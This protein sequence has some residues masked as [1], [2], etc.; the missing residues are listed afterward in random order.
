MNRRILYQKEESS[1]G[2]DADF[3]SIRILTAR[4]IEQV[5]D[6]DISI[7]IVLNLLSNNKKLYFK[8]PLRT[9]NALQY[10]L[11]LQR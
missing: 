3:G 10:I 4:K 11:Q 8:L 1:A 2:T 5:L 6:M 7:C 9:R